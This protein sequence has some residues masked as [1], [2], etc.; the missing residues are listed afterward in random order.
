MKNDQNVGLA[1][2]VGK[3]LILSLCL[4]TGALVRMRAWELGVEGKKGIHHRLISQVS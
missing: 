2:M 1:S 3:R 4:E